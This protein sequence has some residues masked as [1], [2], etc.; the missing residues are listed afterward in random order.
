VE[1]RMNMDISQSSL[2]AAALEERGVEDG[3][4]EQFEGCRRRCIKYESLPLRQ[5][6]ENCPDLLYSYEQ[7][8]EIPIRRGGRKDTYCQFQAAVGQLARFAVAAQ[9]V[10]PKIFALPGGLFQ[11]AKDSKLIRAF[12]GGFQLRA[13]PSTVYSK[14]VLLVRFCALASQ[15]FG[16]IEC[17]NTVPIL[18][19]IAETKNLLGGFA[20]VEKATSR[21]QTAVFRDQN[22]RLTFVN[23]SDWDILQ[24]SIKED[25]NAVT[26]GMGEMTQQF[27]GSVG[28]FL[29]ENHSFVRKFS[30]L[31]L[32]FIVLNGGGQRPQAYTSMIHPEERTLKRWEVEWDSRGSIS[33]NLETVFEELE[34]VKL[35]PAQE[36]TARATLQPAIMFPDNARSYFCKYVYYIRPAIMRWVGKE[37][38]DIL[39]RSRPFLVHTEKGCSLSV[40]N[41][42][43]TL[44]TY[45]SG[46]KGLSGRV[47][48]LSVMT[49][50]A[51][52]AS[53]MFQ[54]FRRGEFG[55]RTI[56][57]FMSELAEIMN[58]SPEMLRATYIATNGKE[59]DAAA[60][61]FIRA[62]RAHEA[63]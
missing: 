6:P 57:E 26:V 56:E 55:N 12:M 44:R 43:S 15:H 16:K 60:R 49:L 38:T 32:I 13:A 7:V 39:Q 22:Q 48:R 59:F 41:L 58:T 11:L 35:Y 2:A 5:D 17:A 51:S 23:E 53:K 27:G 3:L 25:M 9:V 21:R 45:V 34:P 1:A 20:R 36:K 8:F 63:T 28:A 61:E 33:G 24:N 29:D 19:T 10:E 62:A 4:C 31:L 47:E 18:S 40:E 54:A 50:R 42:R 52:Y 46:V 14:A 37:S 30:L